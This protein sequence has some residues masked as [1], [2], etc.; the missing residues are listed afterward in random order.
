VWWCG[1]WLSRWGGRNGWGPGGAQDTN[2]AR[3]ERQL[4]WG[5]VWG[6]GG[7]RANSGSGRVAGCVG[8]RAIGAALPS[9]PSVSLMKWLF[10]VGCRVLVV[11]FVTR[12][13][14][15]WARQGI[16]GVMGGGARCC[17]FVR[18]F[19]VGV[20]GVLIY[21]GLIRWLRFVVFRLGLRGLDSRSGGWLLLG[22]LGLSLAQVSSV[23]AMVGWCVC[24]SVDW[25]GVLLA[26]CR[27]SGLVFL[28]GVCGVCWCV[29]VGFCVCCVG[30]FS[31][32]GVAV[33]GWMVCHWLSACV[34]SGRMLNL[35]CL[36]F[37]FVCCCRGSTFAE[38]L[39]VFF[40]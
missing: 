9:K 29:C 6:G 3:D 17:L 21:W 38:A 32:E 37:S 39:F 40:G 13:G 30:V 25:W 5:G 22:V 8:A 11:L 4:V 27:A 12:L 19:E 16:S 33:V 10:L 28:W 24:G 31:S 35:F 2:D 7:V 18:R 20:W 14:A 36:C 23:L 34:Y 15:L 26:E 1:G